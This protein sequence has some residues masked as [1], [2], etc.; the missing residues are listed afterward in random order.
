MKQTK[1]KGVDLV[2]NSLAEEKLLAS[3]RCLSK[4]G[5]FLEIGKFDLMNHNNL[6]LLAFKQGGN[7][8]GIM[9]DQLFTGDDKTKIKLNRL[10]QKYIDS[11]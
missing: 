6:D 4:N 2:L 7:Y 3:V 1:G 8:H 11:G 10:M 9:L 5:R